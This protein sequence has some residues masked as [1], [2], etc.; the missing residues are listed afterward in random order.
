MGKL[1]TIQ[2]YKVISQHDDAFPQNRR[3]T[4]MHTLIQE[5]KTEGRTKLVKTIYPGILHLVGT[6]VLV[7][8][9]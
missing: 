4:Y 8:A 9:A 5:K 6:K 1:Q 2:V 3:T 7:A